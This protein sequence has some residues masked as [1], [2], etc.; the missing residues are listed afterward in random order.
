M[1]SGL[2]DR[3]SL[4]KP[5]R[6]SR[7]TFVTHGMQSDLAGDFSLVFLSSAVLSL[8]DAFSNLRI[9]L[10]IGLRIGLRDMAGLHQRDDRPR[11]FPCDQISARCHESGVGH[12]VDRC[13]SHSRFCHLL[14][15]ADT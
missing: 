5:T 6:V 4:T 15:S 8:H 3:D 14:L 13:C 1:G 2:L 7:R 9:A 10:R 12:R 11:C